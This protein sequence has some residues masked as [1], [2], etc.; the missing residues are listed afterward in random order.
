MTAFDFVGQN[1]L[2]N[3]TQQ[4][5]TSSGIA[6]AQ[7]AWS[8][9]GTD[10][11]YG[12]KRRRLLAS[13]YVSTACSKNGTC[14]S[15]DTATALAG[16]W[17]SYLVAKNPDFGLDMSEKGFFRILRRSKDEYESLLAANNPDLSEFH[18][19]GGEMITAHGLA[20]QIIPP[21]GTIAYYEEVLK[22]NEN[23]HGFY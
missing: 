9:L 10:S 8:D 18:A 11:S 22:A 2:C 4:T 7:A 14:H 3:G 23:V 1:Y 12:L 5:L 13:Y 6:V 21:N 17:I 19:H 16:V 20:D 15:S